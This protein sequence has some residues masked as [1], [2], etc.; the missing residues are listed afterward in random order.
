MKSNIENNPLKYFVRVEKGLIPKEICKFII[1]SISKESWQK[2]TWSH[3]DKKETFSYTKKELDVFYI[4]SEL[5]YILNPFISKSIKLYNDYLG[6]D[7]V[8]QVI[9]FSPVRFNRYETGTKMRRHCDHIQSL[10]EGEVKGI[11]TLSII[12]N[13]NDN[14]E[15]GDFVLWDDCK[16]ELGEGDILI[17]PSLFLFPHRVDEVTK[18]IRYSGVCWGC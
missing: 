2:H 15:G 4:T 6:E 5:E 13:F 12:L 8:S 1:D 18:N 10:F 16:V 14:Y 3:K 17:F 9:C 7:K 11:P